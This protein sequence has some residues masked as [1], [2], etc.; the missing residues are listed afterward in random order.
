MS[1]I[2]HIMI[3]RGGFG[4]DNHLIDALNKF[5]K[6]DLSSIELKQVN[7]YHTSGRAFIIPVYLAAVNHLNCDGLRK[8]F[9]KH[10]K[11]GDQLFLMDEDEYMFK[12]YTC[13]QLH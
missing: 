1:N 4:D 8:C 12:E 9:N 6:E 2:T 7:E 11:D 13:S 3:T 10:K 5:L